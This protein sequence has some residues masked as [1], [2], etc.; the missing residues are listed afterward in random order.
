M[1]LKKGDV[2]KG[3]SGSRY[4]VNRAPSRP[5][6]DSRSTQT[7]P[8]TETLDVPPLRSMAPPSV[9]PQK[10]LPPPPAVSFKGKNPKGTMPRTGPI[11]NLPSKRKASELSLASDSADEEEI[12]PVIR[13][14]SVGRKKA[15]V[16]EE[17]MSP[18]NEGYAE[19]EE[20]S[21]GEDRTDTSRPNDEGGNEEEISAG[22][23]GEKGTAAGGTGGGGSSPVGDNIAG[24][25]RAASSRK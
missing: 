21:D 22:G 2:P 18:V 16:Y 24:P 5:R 19:D 8:R 7:P 9:S 25:S 15:E 23:G 14:L 6:E 11:K 13:S 1:P 20:M 17:V 3:P 10:T 4:A 12:V